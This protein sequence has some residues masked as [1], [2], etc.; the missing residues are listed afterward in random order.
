MKIITVVGARPQ[1]IKAAAVSREIAM[2]RSFEE[3]MVHTGQHFDA[4]M[5]DVFFREMEIPKPKFNL[6]IFGKTH[7]AMTG[8][9]MIKIEEL[10]VSEQ[11]DLMLVYGDTNSTLAGAL[12]AAKLKIP[13]AHVEAGLR[14]FNMTMPEEINRVLTDRVSKYLFCPSESAMKNLAKEGYNTLACKVLNSGDVMMDAALYYSKISEKRS[15]I[16]AD[17]K[18][19]DYGLCTI[20]RAENTDSAERLNQIF[21]ALT[22]ISLEKSIVLPLHPRTR[23]FIEQYKIE[24]K[25]IKII[26][27]VGYFDMLELLK[28]ASFVFTDSGGLQKEAY[29]F[30]K[31]CITMRDETEW[32]E[33]VEIGQNVITGANSD[34]ILKAYH[35]ATDQRVWPQ[36]LYG[37]GDASKKIVAHL[38]EQI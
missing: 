21:S 18:L 27:P 10:C 35:Q 29:F 2:Q 8:E 34:R 14:S 17:L 6:G 26:D 32:T 15:K 19:S 5:S 28:N 25:N 36:G 16:V 33:L 38:M 31:P 12:A 9:M 23:K 30:D 24:T 37:N 3:I 4:N 13:I 7:S 1:F 22:E 11:P 20:H